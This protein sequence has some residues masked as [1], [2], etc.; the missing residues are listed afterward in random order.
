MDMTQ[1]MLSGGEKAFLAV[2][3]HIFLRRIAGW[4][5]SVI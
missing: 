2:I 5:L 3:L 4:H 1:F